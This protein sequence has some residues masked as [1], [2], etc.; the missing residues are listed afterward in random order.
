[1]TQST[2]P[3]GWRKIPNLPGIWYR[4]PKRN[5]HLFDNMQTFKLGSTEAE[6]YR[7]WYERTGGDDTEIEETTVEYVLD[8]YM[9]N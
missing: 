3:K 8:A 9:E 6:A 4:V 2:L 1:M 7:T 5:R